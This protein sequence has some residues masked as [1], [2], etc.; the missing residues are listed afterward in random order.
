MR[1]VRYNVA[2]SLDGYIADPAGGYDWIPNDPAVDFAAIFARVDTVLLGRH[3]YELVGSLPEAPWPP[4]R[5]CTCS[6]GR[7]RPSRAGGVTVV[8]PADGR[9]RWRRS[10]PSPATATSGC[11]AGARCSAASSRRGRSTRSR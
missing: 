4:A 8:R 7:S 2:A 10:A 1:R 3:S 11:S 6:R 9:R 5:A